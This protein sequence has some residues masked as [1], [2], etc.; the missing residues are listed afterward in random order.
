MQF[1]ESLNVN[2]YPNHLVSTVVAAWAAFVLLVSMSAFRVDAN[3]S[4]RMNSARMAIVVMQLCHFF[5][6]LE[7][8]ASARADFTLLVLFR[9]PCPIFASNATYLRQSKERPIWQI[10]VHQ[11]EII[12][13][14]VSRLAL[15]L[16]VSLGAHGHAPESVGPN[17]AD[18]FWPFSYHTMLTQSFP[19]RQSE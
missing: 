3:V 6:P 5:P 12:Y 9:E 1:L 4:N 2:S 10:I 16:P 11:P 18:F 15:R 8:A 19:W 17:S 14:V 7:S 13:A